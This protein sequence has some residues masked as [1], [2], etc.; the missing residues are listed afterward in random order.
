MLESHQRLREG[1]KKKFEET[2]QG[3]TDRIEELQREIAQIEPEDEVTL[4]H[5]P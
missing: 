5:K 2:L 3:F 4:N 1:D